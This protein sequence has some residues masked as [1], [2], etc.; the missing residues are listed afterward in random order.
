M[1]VQILQAPHHMQYQ[2]MQNGSLTIGDILLNYGNGT[3]W[4]TNTSGL[5]LECL[6]NTEI[7]IHDSGNRVASFMLY[8]GGATPMFTIGRDM[9][10]GSVPLTIANNLKVSGTTTLNGSTTCNSS[11][12]VIGNIT[13]SGLSVFGINYY[14]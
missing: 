13:T 10:W 7:A 14:I 5:L 4:T 11:L 1:D 3:N 2:I 8:Q 6:D 12:N 9:F